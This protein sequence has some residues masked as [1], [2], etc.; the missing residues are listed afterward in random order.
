MALTRAMLKGMGLTEEQVSAIIEEHTSVTTSL[1]D[2]IKQYKAD[3]EKLP[4]VQKELEDL[5]KDTS[6]ADWE[7]K[8]NDE[9]G[10]FEAYKKDIS[11]KETAARLRSAYK[12]L[13]AECKVGDRHIDSIL[14]VTDFS[15]MKLDK[16]GALEGAD[17]L[18]EGIKS[19]WAGFIGSVSRKPNGNPA[20]PPGDD[21]DPDSKKTG[22]AAQLAAKY[23]D[24][25]YGKV[26]EG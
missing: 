25:L 14:K 17:E 6:A 4:G 9:H 8:Y 13:L 12:K 7:R 20:N 10:A 26:E 21:G 11:D 3:A 22:R 19:D 15:G 1:K 18:R 23:H 16:D 2:Q 24:N 5:K